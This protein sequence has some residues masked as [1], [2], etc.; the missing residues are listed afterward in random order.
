MFMLN[1]ILVPID[2]S[3]H[4]EK[5]LKQA[6]WLAS[7]V[8]GTITVLYVVPIPFT[9]ESAGLPIEPLLEAGQKVLEKA[10]KI[11]KNEKCKCTDFVLREASGNAGHEIV[12]Y[13]EE[14]KYSLIVMSAKGHSAL[15]H[16]LLGS[17][18]NTVTKH[19]PCSVLIVK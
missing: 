13:A 8:D 7:K 6:C 5:G 1:K 14:K 4:S 11:V 15:K 18:S 2:G 10:K 16:L 17:V 12:K 19:A 3:K 9:G